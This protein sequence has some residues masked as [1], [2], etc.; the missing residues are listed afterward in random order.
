MMDSEAFW[1]LLGL[2][3]IVYILVGP[4]FGIIAWRRN[5]DTAAALKSLQETVAQQAAEIVRLGGT[6]VAPTAATGA[7][8]EAAAPVVAAPAAPEPAAPAAEE[9]APAEPPV[10][11]ADTADIVPPPP[12]PEPEPAPEPVAIAARSGGVEQALT[13]RW[14][15]WLGAVTIALAGIFL[16]KY[17]IDHG[18]LGPATR[19]TLGFVAGVALMA[20]GEWLRRRPSERAIAAVRASFVP[21]ALTA[22][23][24]FTAFASIYAAYELYDLLL[25]L[26]AFLA[27]AALVAV[28]IGL[29]VLQGPFIALLGLAGGFLTPLLVATEEPSVWGLFVYLLFL[30]AGGLGVVRLMVW[31]WLAW[32]TLIGAAIW[33]LLWFGDA[34]VSGDALAIGIFLTL[35]A[36]LYI[37]VLDRRG[38][39]PST[40]SWRRPLEA[41]L[42][43]E[44]VTLVAIAVIALLVFAF[45]RM[46]SYGAVS[47]MTLALFAVGLT[48]AA[49]RNAGVDRLLVIAAV[50]AFA[51]IATWHLPQIITTDK[52]MGVVEGQPT[53][54]IPGAIVP[55]ELVQFLVWTGGLAALF[56]IGG[57][58]LMWGAVRP[59]LWAGVSAAMPVLLLAICYWRILEFGLDLRW[60]LLAVG[61]GG[62][63]V[64]AAER[65]ERHRQ[66]PGQGEALGAYAA[67]VVAAISLALAMTLREAWLTV[68]LSAQL[69]ALAWLNRR[70][71]QR[72]L[73]GLAA[74]VA[75]IV[76][77]RL[78]FNPTVVD[79]SLPQLPILNWVL[80]GYGVPAAAFL[81]AAWWFADKAEPWL[82]T[83]LESGALVFAVLL[84]SFEI[85]IAIE[86]DIAAPRYRLVEQSLNAIAWA[87]IGYALLRQACIAPRPVLTWGW[88]ILAVLATAQVLCLHLVAAN[89]LWNRDEVGTLP[90]INVLGLAYAAPAAFAF[91]YARKLRSMGLA[92]IATIAAIFG[93]VLSFVYLSLEVRHAFQG[94]VLSG[95]ET[96]DT[97]WYSYSVA[98]LAYA[99]VLL[100]L[101][102]RLVSPPLRYASLAIVLLTVAKVFLSDMAD[103]T[104]LLRVASFLGLG[105]SLV[106][107]GFLYQRFVFP[108]GRAE[109]AGPEPKA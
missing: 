104:G 73:R 24:L 25:P 99:G 38:S 109:E 43:P 12:L 26:V 88:R 28:A 63:G 90:V 85:R 101:G 78:V 81:L 82:T 23:G 37:G 11:V 89:P 41:L 18:W 57:F 93:L 15:V 29:S 56:G 96:S 70:L 30:V 106:G 76:L 31:W 1:I 22:A 4:A 35:L 50:L 13:S 100:A 44:G 45:L 20:G 74:I 95:N 62:L 46:D 64:F 68:S 14:L 60:A 36:A 16:V 107:I 10:V 91:V 8:L 3:A 34:W 80:Y 42:E 51:A 5:R 72:S 69:P 39:D 48:G 79:Y 32:A 86:G 6:V 2:C 67:A 21:P 33:V 27:M 108:I 97:E 66:A 49:R 83:L 75:A 65:I 58:V 87:A 17:G 47:L 9:L 84:V 77:I 103:L 53:G 59:G 52:P 19:V 40:L 71:D 54:F 105:L 61:V 102:I 7:P 94:P 55:P 98:W 92:Q